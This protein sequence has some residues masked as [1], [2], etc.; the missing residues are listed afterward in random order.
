MFK[1]KCEM[2][3][4]PIRLVFSLLPQ[5]CFR[6]VL[7]HLTKALSICIALVV[8]HFFSL[9]DYYDITDDAEH[10]CLVFY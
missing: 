8:D 3:V 10:R 1:I 4:E 2:A 7:V 5:V 6:I 9:R